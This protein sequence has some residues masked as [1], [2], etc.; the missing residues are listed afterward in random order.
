MAIKA[1]E[2]DIMIT[3]ENVFTSWERAEK[4]SGIISMVDNN[5]IQFEKV[6]GYRNRA[7]K[8]LNNRDT[9][10]ATASGT[11]LFTAVA[12]CKLIDQGEVVGNLHHVWVSKEQVQPVP[13]GFRVGCVFTNRV[14][15]RQIYG[16][17][18]DHGKADSH[19]VAL[20]CIQCDFIFFSVFRIRRS[21]E[22]EGNM[23]RVG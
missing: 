6:Q 22:V 3:L 19:D 18:L 17:T 5:G 20:V 12:I 16:I 23:G 2:N 15:Q 9:A 11:K 13:Y 1:F 7:E 21:F 4:F 8:L 14:R 10:F